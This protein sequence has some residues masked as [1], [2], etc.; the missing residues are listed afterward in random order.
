M[1][2]TTRIRNRGGE[3]QVTLQTA[4]GRVVLRLGTQGIYVASTT[5]PM[6]R[7]NLRH[8]SGEMVSQAAGGGVDG[9][10]A[11]V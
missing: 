6:R 2:K 3:E 8:I 4:T 7:V 10:G 9:E 5:A 1:T 11:I